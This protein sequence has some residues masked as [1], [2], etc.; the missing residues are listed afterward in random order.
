MKINVLDSN[1]VKKLRSD[2]AF[3]SV[4]HC[5]EE[6]VWNSID[7]RAT[8]VAV[9]LN[10]PFYKI[11]VIDNGDGI[12]SDQMDLVGERYAT[13]KCHS[14]ED[15]Q[16]LQ[17]G[18]FRGEA[19][20]SLKDI[21]SNL[22]IESRASGCAE[23]Y[24]KIFNHGKSRSTTISVNHRPSKGTTVTVFNFMYN[25]PVRRNA[26]SEAIDVEESCKL[27]QSIALIHPDISFSLMNEVTGEMCLQFKKCSSLYFAFVQ[28]FGK[29]KARN[30]KTLDHHSENYKIS[31]CISTDC[32][33]LKNYQFLYVNKRLILKTRLHKLINNVLNKFLSG[34]HKA[35]CDALSSSPQILSPSKNQYCAF[36]LN[37][38]CP[39]DAYDTVF[40]RK[41]TLVEFSEWDKV[42]SVV[43]DSLTGFLVNQRLLSDPSRK[44]DNQLLNLEDTESR[45]K[46][47]N[48]GVDNFRNGLFSHAVKRRNVAAE[49]SNNPT[50][51]VFGEANTNAEFIQLDSLQ[52]LE[53][54]FSMPVKDGSTALSF[55]DQRNV[56]IEKDDNTRKNH[57]E[58]EPV[59]KSNYTERSFI[60]LK[61]LNV[62]ASI[63][64]GLKR[65]NN[66]YKISETRDSFSLSEAPSTSEVESPFKISPKS[67]FP[68]ENPIRLTVPTKST[69]SL[70]EKERRGSNAVQK[71]KEKYLH[72]PQKR[73]KTLSNLYEESRRFNGKMHNQAFNNNMNHN[74]NL[75]KETDNINEETESIFVLKNKNEPR[76]TSKY[77]F[78]ENSALSPLKRLRRCKNLK[79]L[80]SVKTI[81][82]DKIIENI[83]KETNIQID[84]LCE[85]DNSGSSQPLTLEGKTIIKDFSHLKSFQALNDEIKYDALL[86]EKSN[87][88]HSSIDIS[89][90]IHVAHSKFEKSDHSDD[91]QEKQKVVIDKEHIHLLNKATT[92]KSFLK[93]KEV[94]NDERKGNSFLNKL[95]TYEELVEPPCYVGLHEMKFNQET[96]DREFASNTFELNNFLHCSKELAKKD[97]IH[98]SD[99]QTSQTQKENEKFENIDQVL[100]ITDDNSV[101]TSELSD[102]HSKKFYN[103]ET[104]VK[105]SNSS[106][107]PLQNAGIEVLPFICDKDQ[108]SSESSDYNLTEK[109]SSFVNGNFS[110]NSSVCAISIISDINSNL[111]AEECLS[112]NP[113]PIL[114]SLESEKYEPASSSE[115]SFTVDYH[116]NENEINILADN[117]HDSVV[118][119]EYN[120]MVESSCDLKFASTCV[121]SDSLSQKDISV[122]DDFSKTASSEELKLNFAINDHSN[123]DLSLS[124]VNAEDILPKDNTIACTVTDPPT[125]MVPSTFSSNEAFVSFHKH[126]LEPIVE[127]SC[128]SDSPHI[129]PLLNQNEERRWICKINES[130]KHV[131]YIDS[132]TGNSSYF[133]P[134]LHNE[135]EKQS[136]NEESA[137]DHV[138]KPHFFLTHDFS[139]FVPES[140]SSRNTLDVS[141]EICNLQTD[142]NNYMEEKETLD[143]ERKWRYPMKEVDTYNDIQNMYKEWENP[144]FDISSEGINLEKS[145]ISSL[146]HMCILNSYRFTQSSLNSLKVIGQVDCKF[147]A[148]IIK[149]FN[150]SFQNKNLLVLF[151]Q[152]AVHE[153]VRLE[154]LMEDLFEMKDNKRIVKTMQ[155]NPH[156]NIAL[157]PEAMRLLHS[158]HLFLKEI[159]FDTYFTDEENIISVSSLPLCL[160]NKEN[161]QLKKRL[162]E[163]VMLV[164]KIIKEWLDSLMQTRS[165]SSVLPKTLSAVLNS[166]ACRGAVKFGDPLDLSQ[167]EHL[168]TALSKCKL[169]FQCAHG[170]PSIAPILDI[171]KIESL[172]KKRIIPKLW[173][174]RKTFTE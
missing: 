25:R 173:K 123:K 48:L 6:L 61:S 159:G 16:N 92:K 129:E 96:I 174:L 33:P 90:N 47:L 154:E 86:Q 31:G 134:D 9:R 169:P 57:S 130:N 54:E 126:N 114:S 137:K 122:N 72:V 32:F 105:H 5:I 53:P 161:N 112:V 98:V 63:F 95:Q 21:S 124:S 81:Q 104:K 39:R 7:A 109:A 170:R 74:I 67:L 4:S 102:L 2:V 93:I 37:I 23:T 68:V 78:Q 139:P 89:N 35:E 165:I 44:S 146:P 79:A 151:D 17:Y 18:G 49:T 42:S 60:H 29:D 132:I 116:T 73:S 28:L 117:V 19:L 69:L 75:C 113:S 156:I 1:V 128:E 99:I 143:W 121:T 80:P 163:T 41:R 71:L 15:L 135:E 13:S 171:S 84:S 91:L 56:N 55:V 14:I 83:T 97:T 167:C 12:P 26:I 65:T 85:G 148:C 100:N 101:P 94:T 106:L 64:S 88:D 108:Q 51:V 147:I 110:G 172:N 36:V 58:E 115:C 140:T 166:Q 103:F 59:S 62:D 45:N 43:H 11:Q 119:D 76:I 8:C 149:E 155:V 142:L 20:S 120:S 46:F 157:E 127:Q 141:K 34:K 168:L 40:D 66:N 30:L 125:N 131:A 144:M 77:T 118:Y 136:V 52:V 70:L 10:L 152:H 150:D 38:S 22:M 160:F 111:V 164:E 87:D 82:E 3:T 50:D 107:N 24:C 145:Q 158:Y 133:A 153:R 27:L 162:S 138:K